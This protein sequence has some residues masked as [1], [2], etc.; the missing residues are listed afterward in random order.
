VN[1]VDELEELLLQ[2]SADDVP[3][4]M[5]WHAC[6]DAT[7]TDPV[8]HATVHVDRI[9]SMATVQVVV[10]QWHSGAPAALNA[11][12]FPLREFPLECIESCVLRKCD[13]E[14]CDAFARRRL[15]P[16]VHDGWFCA[17]HVWD[18]TDAGE[19]R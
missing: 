15:P 4:E 11:S 19:H 12:R 8:R 2:A 13:A 14:D 9:T 5:I 17:T 7:P 6:L 3:V 10:L 1:T 18:S 16:T